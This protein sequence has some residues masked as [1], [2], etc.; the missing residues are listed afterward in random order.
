MKHPKI[1]LYNATQ[2]NASMIQIYNAL[3]Q[4]TR[5]IYYEHE[6]IYK[7]FAYERLIYKWAAFE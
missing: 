7:Q 3:K 5:R 6:Y 2:D 4:L 1:Q